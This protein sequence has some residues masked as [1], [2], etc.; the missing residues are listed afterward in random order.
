MR[1]SLI[2][3]YSK[4]GTTKRYAE[5]IGSALNGD[6]FSIKSFNENVITNYDTIILG[7][8]LYAGGIKGI[9][10]IINNYEK[11][12]DRKL[13]LFT[14]GLGDPSAVETRGS[15]DKNL[16]KLI[17][18]NIRTNMKVFYL[19]GGVDYKKLGLI[20][21]I[22]MS[23]LKGMIMK[24][25]HDKMNDEDRAFLATYGKK[26]DFTDKSNITDLLEYCGK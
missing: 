21:K 22:M 2:L 26:V 18:G 6:I 16:E 23:L 9:N 17:P 25:G 19:H 24:K 5:W 7:S 4:Y 12:K 15:I 14:C 10:I 8:G 13:V 20:H 3:Y 1:K 11:I